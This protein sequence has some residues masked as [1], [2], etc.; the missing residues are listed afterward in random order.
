MEKKIWC[1][2]ETVF[3]FSDRPVPAHGR[4]RTKRPWQDNRSHRWPLAG[5]VARID[6]AGRLPQSKNTAMHMGE[7]KGWLVKSIRMT[8]LALVVNGGYDTV[9]SGAPRGFSPSNS[10]HFTRVGSRCGIG[11]ARTPVSYKQNI[12]TSFVHSFGGATAWSH[13]KDS[14]EILNTNKRGMFLEIL[15]LPLLAISHI[16]QKC[17]QS[18]ISRMKT[19]RSLKKIVSTFLKKTFI[20]IWGRDRNL[21]NAGICLPILVVLKSATQPPLTAALGI[22]ENKGK[23]LARTASGRLPTQHPPEPWWDSGSP[24]APSRAVR[25]GQCL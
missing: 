6:N 13:Q 7:L 12:F 19:L 5:S 1:C 3:R 25:E 4:I 14:K 20:I 17:W 15:R 24:S 9:K 21:P 16:Q 23:L 18:F 22:P 11:G 8:G 2:H 10:P